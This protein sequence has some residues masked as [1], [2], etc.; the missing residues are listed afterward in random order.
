MLKIA[1]AQLNPV[2]GALKEN[3]E[4]ILTTCRDLSGKADLIVFNE[5]VLTGYPLE[6]LTR[7]PFFIARVHAY[8]EKIL[9][10]LPDHH[11]ALALSTPWRAVDGKLYN[12][13][14][15][16]ENRHITAVRPKHELP[17]YGVFDEV[18]IFDAG[19]LPEPVNFK[20]YRLGLMTCEDMWK[21]AVTEHLRK[22]GAEL[23]IAANGS[24][25]EIEKFHI[26]IDHAGNRAKE[27]GLPLIYINQCGGQD[28]IVFDGGS[29]IL[30]KNGQQILLCPSHTEHVCVTSWAPDPES[31]AR[32]I[33]ACTDAPASVPLY[34]D[35]Q[36][37]Y[38]TLQLGLRDY[39]GKNGFSGVLVGMSGGIDSALT[40][41]LAVDALGAENVLCVAMP[42]PHSSADS[43]K[44]AKTCAMLLGAPLQS[45]PIDP[46]I[47][48]ITAMTA[49]LADIEGVTAENIQARSRGMFLMT[50]SNATG[51]MVL[52]TG[53][54]SESA[55]G[56]ATLY[57]DM[58]GGF[59]P[60]KDVYKT[61]VYALARWRNTN[62]PDFSRGPEGRVIPETILNKAPTAEL[63]P[64]QKDEDN[65]PSYEE[66]D[67]I[68]YCL[69]EKELGLE[70]IT[71]RGHAPET[72]NKIWRLLDG[73]EFKRRQGA[74]GIKIT[75]KAFGRDRRYPVT[76]RFLSLLDDAA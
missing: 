41:A 9:G 33:L 20:G 14:L 29:F 19:P 64:D 53:N 22:T 34:D 69:I 13:I 70:D 31:N 36:G 23:L 57:G 4:K 15:F 24:P 40:A 47:D 25:F 5:L 30:D 28:E 56:Y 45:V 51:N 62:Y 11:P 2:L 17:N 1:L 67:D 18:R 50:L 3:A 75:F 74:P 73:A 12:A 54:K 76:N 38:Q 26:R 8:V 39:V 61:L 48:A 60:L 21:P 10:S 71:A 66:L 32:R 35:M 16:I 7:K 6:D 49:P 52:A 72:V 65:L 37:I 55:V 27:S 58:C 68:L 46:A 43:L 44:D 42:S 63:R 59:A